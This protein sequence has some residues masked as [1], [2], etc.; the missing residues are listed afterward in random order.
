MVGN[1]WD[2]YCLQGCGEINVIARIKPA[3]LRLTIL[4][5]ILVGTSALAICSSPFEVP[6]RMN[7]TWGHFVE[8]RAKIG[9]FRVYLVYDRRVSFCW[10]VPTGMV[11]LLP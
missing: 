8:D 7:W 5:C 1:R 10:P 2:Q 11:P 3:G 9:L 6:V 4:V